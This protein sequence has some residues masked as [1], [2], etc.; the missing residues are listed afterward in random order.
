MKKKKEKKTYYAVMVD[1][2]IS[3]SISSSLAIFTSEKVAERNARIL[4]G[5]VITVKVTP[6]DNINK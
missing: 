4:N 6:S 1:G 5:K 3:E 2:E